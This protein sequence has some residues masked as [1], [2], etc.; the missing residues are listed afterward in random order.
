MPLAQVL[1]DLRDLN[2]D[3][4]PPLQYAENTGLLFRTEC[5]LLH[6]QRGF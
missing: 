5:W 4:E 1:G 6:I 2:N 3:L